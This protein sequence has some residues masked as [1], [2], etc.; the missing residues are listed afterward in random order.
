MKYIFIVVSLIVISS[1]K[2]YS[3]KFPLATE[4]LSSYY[5]TKFINQSIILEE[6]YRL[7]LD[8]VVLRLTET[9]EPEEVIQY[10]VN[11]YKLKYGVK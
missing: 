3:T 6:K 4:I 1:C 5:K 9:K 11:D 7:V 8:T 2:Q 10:I